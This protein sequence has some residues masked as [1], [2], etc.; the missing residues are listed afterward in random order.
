MKAFHTVAVPHQ[1]ILEGRLTMDVFA[2]DLWE[3]SQGR[4][5]DEYRDPETF[6][7]KTYLTEGLKNLLDVVERRLRGKVGDP[8][9]QIQTPFGGGKTH[10]LI[11]MYHKAAT[12]W[13]ARTAVAVGTAL[14]TDQTLWG[15]LEK[16]LTGKISRFGGQVAPGKEALRSLLTEHAP[17]LLLMDEILEY[18]TK[19]AGVKIAESTLAAQ[20]IAFMQ[21][22]TECVS[23]MPGVCLVVT[24]PSSI[25]EHYDEQAERYYQQ[26]QKVSGRIEKIYTPVQE[27]EITKVIRRRLFSRVDESAAKKAVA[28]FLDY[29]EKEGILPAGIQPSDYRD[30]FA[31]AYP[32]LPEVVDV[33]YHRWGSFPTFQRTRGVLRLLSLVIHDLKG[34]NKPFISLADF[35]LNRQ[36]IRQEFLKH[37]GSAFNSVI[38]ADITDAGAGARKVD[39]ALG[40]AYK[41]LQLG[42]RTARAI[43]LYSFSGGSMKGVTLGE[44]K[45]AATTVENPASAVAEA[46]EQLKNMLF[47]LQSH[48]DLYFFSNQPNLHRIRLTKTENIPEREIVEAERD[49]LKA[50]LKGGKLKLFVWEENSGN[51]PDNEELKLA[52]MKKEN[53][54]V[55]EALS[56]NKGQT[57]RVNRNTLFFLYPLETERPG[58]VS[59]VKLKIACEAVEE[60]RTL[61]LS[62]DQKKENKKELKK[63]EENVREV[64][65][66]LYR[67]IAVPSREGFKEID[68]GIPTYGEARSLDQEVYEKLHSDGEILDKIAPLVLKEKYLN[69]KEFLSTEQLYQT[70]LR[71]PG[72]TRFTGRSVIE[73]GLTEGVCLG[74]FGLG[75]LEEG[76]PV[77]RYF[78]EKPSLSFAGREVLIAEA[79][80]WAQRSQETDTAGA[81]KS[82]EQSGLDLVNGKD[83]G[84]K[85]AA[86]KIGGIPTKGKK[87][88]VRLCFQ[89]PKGK[90]SGIMGVMNLL[91]SKFATLELEI[92]ATDGAIS[93]QE[94]ED[95]IEETFRQLGIEVKGQ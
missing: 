53:G 7:R 45:R 86:E 19:A 35:D 51:I 30:R 87:D 23:A 61:N 27:D 6:F 36:E 82:Y 21:E 34:A 1:D 50:A 26:L 40:N 90:V 73:N 32:F 72:E 80:C 55:L 43:F 44:V 81:G 15:W 4:G 20:T 31:D 77:C 83:A 92:T 49:L 64:I 25:L 56:K 74:L 54:N 10:A 16:Q 2:A 57:P 3:V 48:G 28:G 84:M 59:A 76:Q 33:L 89:I 91:Q 38:A 58:F 94:F 12:E 22:L 24:L 39:G 42:T 85:K 46:V 14:G 62:D 68:M 41:G 63:A 93:E 11:A 13:Q 47:F 66:R 18:V 69:G 37:I 79:V 9:I 29:A 60:D 8:V 5:P 71:T 17:V 75:N 95:K 52:I 88:R 70:F 78:K 65:R 67:L